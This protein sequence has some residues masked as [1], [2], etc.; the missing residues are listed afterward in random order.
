[1]VIKACDVDVAAVADHTL[2]PY[3]IK[4]SPGENF[5]IFRPGTPWVYLTIRKRSLYRSAS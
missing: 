4:F 1:M 2:V 5:R 3:S